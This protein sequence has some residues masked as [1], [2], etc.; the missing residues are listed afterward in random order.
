MYKVIITLYLN[1]YICITISVYLVS[2]SFMSVVMCEEGGDPDVALGG[3][4]PRL[5]VF[6]L[7]KLLNV[8]SDLHGKTSQN[9]SC[10]ISQATLNG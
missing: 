1:G 8:A 5:R 3:S 4:V 2:V 9:R 10:S 6:S 7:L